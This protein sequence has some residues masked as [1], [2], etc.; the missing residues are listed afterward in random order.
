MQYRT[1]AFKQLD[2]PYNWNLPNGDGTVST[3]INKDTL[4]FATG[5]A[6]VSYSID[7]DYMVAN[8]STVEIATETD[9][10]AGQIIALID[11]SETYDLGLITSVDNENLKIL[12]KSLLSL[13]DSEILNPARTTNDDDA[14]S[15]L[16]D[17]VNG[18]AKILASYYASENVD[19][20]RRLPLYIRTSGGGY[21]ADGNLCVPA[22][23]SYSDNTIN[24][25]SW[26]IDLFDTHNVVLQFRLVFETSRA[27]I[28]VY[29]QH[30][31]TGGHLIK[32]NIH[33][34]TVNHEEESSASAT[35]CQVIDSDTKVL[36]STWYLLSDNTVTKDA[37]DVKRVQPYKLTVAEF[38][39]DNDD[40][41]TEQ[42]IVEDAML[43][44]DFNHYI[45]I[46]MDRSSVMFP[47]NL[48]IGDAV[49]I[50]TDIEEMTEGQEIDEDYDDKIYKSIYTGRKESSSSSEV[51]L[52]FG[53]IRI[54]YTDLIQIQNAKKVRT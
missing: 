4:V 42:T 35:V 3:F 44:S 33:G 51:T 20:Y 49:T 39:S 37:S 13:F 26:L 6:I 52:I 47:S 9:A 38:D 32:N 1:F 10:V 18:T 8:N 25:R 54:S 50:V 17:G 43:Y 14:V 31:T 15:Y 28:D 30:N 22:I 7:N 12:Y 27:Y 40:G 24:I 46:S 36:L 53:K 16:Y 21:G 19:K 41:A 48:N 34:M 29:I 11:G 23:W 45:N 5:G 2:S